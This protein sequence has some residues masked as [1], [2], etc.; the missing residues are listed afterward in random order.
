[1]HVQY[2]RI[3]CKANLMLIELSRVKFL[4]WQV[5][6][7]RT[8]GVVLGDWGVSAKIGEVFDD[9]THSAFSHA[10]YRSHSYGAGCDDKSTGTN[11]T[12]IAITNGTRAYST[13]PRR[14]PAITAAG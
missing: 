8:C 7:R 10:F 1:M 12:E 2:L 5:R 4:N 11:R 9:Q 13:A 14:D 3:Y 6:C